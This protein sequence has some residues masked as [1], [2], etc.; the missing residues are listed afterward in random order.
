MVISIKEFEQ[1]PQTYFDKI[2]EGVKVLIK[3]GKDKIYKLTASK[4]DDSLMTKE[5]F[6]AMIDAGLKD[7]EEGR[8]ITLRTKEDIHNFFESL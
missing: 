7:Y 3:R 8:Y 4:K 2:D 1:N 6:D 5:E